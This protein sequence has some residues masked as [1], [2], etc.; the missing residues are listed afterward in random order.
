MTKFADHAVYSM[1]AVS[2]FCSNL[3]N[4]HIAASFLR[5]SGLTRGV[6]HAMQCYFR[7]A[8]LAM[9]GSQE[10][11]AFY[12][13]RQDD[14]TLP[15]YRSGG[16]QH[17]PSYCIHPRPP[18]EGVAP[19]RGQ[20]HP[21]RAIR[22]WMSEETLNGARHRGKYGHHRPSSRWRCERGVSRALPP[23]R[24]CLLS[25]KERRIEKYWSEK[26]FAENRDD[27]PT[28]RE[29]ALAEVRG[30]FSADRSCVTKT[31]SP[32]LIISPLQ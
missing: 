21:F 18:Q 5:S 4:N 9:T 28:T 2:Y 13:G 3:P 11:V 29:G 23:K 26:G 1:C 7:A 10:S 24:L 22:T 6:V 32:L 20:T 30:D 31:G 12:S 19:W 15:L 27:R 16:G 14:G 8:T 17:A 25:R